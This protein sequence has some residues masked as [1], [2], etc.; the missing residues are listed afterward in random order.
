MSAATPD[1]V[2]DRG[3]IAVA[4][5]E[6]AAFGGTRF[7]AHRP[8]DELEALLGDVVAG[9]WWAVSGPLVRVVTPR[10][11]A[12]SSSARVDSRQASV[13]IRLT[14]E[15]LTLSTVAH[16]LAHALA[17]V[18]AA[19]GPHFR[20]AYVDVVAVLA[21]STVAEHLAEAFVRFGVPS[22]PRAWPAPFRARGDTF[23]IVP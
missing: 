10:R 21:G 19:H 14:D 8:R 7:D 5:A 4:E 3:R 23:A 2:G 17:G 9:P 15:Q 16:E 1:P 12:R 6:A 13:E 18:A 20:A 22:G 11:S